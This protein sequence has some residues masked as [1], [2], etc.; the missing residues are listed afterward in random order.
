MLNAVV[1]NFQFHRILLAFKMGA[2]NLSKKKTRTLGFIGMIRLKKT[3][4]FF[5]LTASKTAS[6]NEGT[7]TECKNEA[8]LRFYH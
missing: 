1:F 4:S 3:T 2:V 5:G 6:K 8:L 7:K